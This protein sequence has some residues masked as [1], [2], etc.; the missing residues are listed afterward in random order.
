LRCPLCDS[1][2]RQTKTWSAILGL[3]IYF[4][5]ENCKKTFRV[6]LSQS[7]ERKKCIQPSFFKRLYIYNRNSHVPS[8]DPIIEN[9]KV[10]GAR[11]LDYAFCA[12][13][14]SRR[15]NEKVILELQEVTQTDYDELTEGQRKAMKSAR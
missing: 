13:E 2:M 6:V 3:S 5:C 12:R 9:V 11:N 14:P 15:D 7:V 10:S 4:D 1:M 8:N